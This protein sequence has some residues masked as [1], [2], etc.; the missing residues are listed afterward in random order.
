[1]VDVS[2]ILV[3]F[4]TFDLIKNALD[5]VF[6]HT[7]AVSFEVIVVDNNS[8]RAI[9]ERLFSLYGD[10]VKVILLPE[11]LGFGRAN[12]EAIKIACGKALFFLNPDT[13]LHNNGIK[14]L[15]DYLYSDTSI[16]A[17]G[18]NL[19]NS[20]NKPT[21]SFGRLFPT[22][23]YELDILF[24]RW[25]SLVRFGRNR[26]YNYSNKPIRV[27]Y[28]TGAALM[29]KSSVINEIGAFDPDFF[30][31][32]EDTELCYRIN[33]KGYTLK[34]V[35]WVTIQHLEGGS[36]QF[37]ETREKLVLQ[38]RMI[39]LRKIYR[40]NPRMIT[41][42]NIIAKMHYRKKLFFYRFSPTKNSEK[43]AVFSYRLRNLSS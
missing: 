15:Y 5:S 13:V 9:R 41:L 8:D 20:E 17:C 3:N 7:V 16:G 27:A 22:F 37:K 19:T 25:C 23:L 12:N 11:N 40:N 29:V 35:P 2:V 38:N 4:N 31:Y 43:I 1:M 14:M 28:I 10:S 39:F 33:Q 24:F 21:H 42:C 26:K 30:M 18:A 36:F 34:N 32:Y 6:R